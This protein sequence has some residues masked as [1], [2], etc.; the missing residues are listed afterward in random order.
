MDGINEQTALL[1]LLHRLIVV[2]WFAQ[3]ADIIDN[4]EINKTDV[5]VVDISC[6]TVAV[7][8]ANTDEVGHASS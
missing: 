8:A 7:A 5:H 2:C 4:D 3:P 6:V 1:F